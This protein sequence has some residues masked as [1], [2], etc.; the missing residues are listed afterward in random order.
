MTG[1]GKY[2]EVCTAA[3]LAARAHGT[4]LIIFQGEHG[5]GFSAQVSSPEM[6]SRIPDAL[7]QVSN[8]IEADHARHGTAEQ[9]QHP[10]SG[11]SAAHC[12]NQAVTAAREA[13]DCAE[14]GLR[15]L[16]GATW[17]LGELTAELVRAQD[18]ARTEALLPVVN[19]LNSGIQLA[20]R[21][22]KTLKELP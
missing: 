11:L 6:L 5:N 10:V 21:A 12:P 13:I 17:H 4:L 14:G 3:R 1:P 7:R 20:Q 2:D 8:E 19:E 15:L 18:A 16:L 9:E 22:L